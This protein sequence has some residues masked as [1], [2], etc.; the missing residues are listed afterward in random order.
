M[1]VLCKKYGMLLYARYFPAEQDG[2]GGIDAMF[3]TL[4]R[5]LYALQNKGIDTATPRQL[6]ENLSSRSQT[7]FKTEL[8]EI[9]RSQIEVMASDPQHAVALVLFKRLQRFGEAIF[10]GKTLQIS[11]YHGRV[12][13]LIEFDDD[14]VP[15]VVS[16]VH[17]IMAENPDEVVDENRV[18]ENVM[19]AAEVEVALFE[20]DPEDENESVVSFECA[21][22]SESHEH[23]EVVTV[24]PNTNTIIHRLPDGFRIDGTDNRERSH[25]R[26]R[27]AQCNKVLVG[28]GKKAKGS[29]Q[30]NKAPVRLL[31][32]KGSASREPEHPQ[33]STSTHQEPRVKEGRVAMYELM[34]QGSILESE[35]TAVCW[36]CRKYFSPPGAMESH[37]CDAGGKMVHVDLATY[38]ILY[39]AHCIRTGEHHVVQRGT[40]DE[41]ESSDALVERIQAA[42]SLEAKRDHI[43]MEFEPGWARRPKRG[44]GKGVSYLKEYRREIYDMF[45]AGEVD[46]RQR[47]APTQMLEVLQK[48]HPGIIALPGFSEISGFVGSL[49]ARAKV[50]KTDYPEPR[51]GPTPA[52]IALS[53]EDLDV[54]WSSEIQPGHT[55]DRPRMGHRIGA[56]KFVVQDLYDAMKE[57]YTTG[58][59]SSLDDDFP[60]PSRFKSLI[61]KQRKAR[62]DAATKGNGQATV[63]LLRK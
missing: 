4:K 18:A 53:I 57:R 30:A 39:A 16:D 35:D 3:G 49:V 36:L 61:N 6:Y 59:P 51:A 5:F 50:G 23:K 33:V 47:K 21:P 41:D 20:G 55:I 31:S 11:E 32:N 46:K 44:G 28:G 52:A 38:G 17:G 25:K 56:K 45:R 40:E 10:D 15:T 43:P 54:L 22:L 1:I 29:R 34:H 60:E 2:K 8:F 12:D 24:L 62:K 14:F 19:S 37:T 9:D 7:N 48:T 27:S 63:N 26:H 13:L 58:D 42:I